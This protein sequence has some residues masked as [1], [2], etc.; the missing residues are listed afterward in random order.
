MQ[1]HI[2]APLLRS[3]RR[4]ATPDEVEDGDNID[5]Y[6]S[7]ARGEI[8]GTQR[9]V[10]S[11]ADDALVTQQVAVW[12]LLRLSPEDADGHSFV[13]N[14]PGGVGQIGRFVVVRGKPQKRRT[15]SSLLR[16]NLGQMRTKDHLC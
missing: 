14:L 11:S 3:L 9:G 2:P 15:V 5:I 12:G 8:L 7:M 16:C 6:S 10:K 13:R 1:G 4:F